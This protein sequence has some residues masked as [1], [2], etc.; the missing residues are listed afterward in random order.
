MKGEPFGEIEYKINRDPDHLSKLTDLF[1][2][3][4]CFYVLN[5]SE[6]IGSRDDNGFRK[7]VEIDESLFFKRK[8]NIGKLSN[9]QL[10]VGE[11]ERGSRKC[12]VVFVA[13][14]NAETMTRVITKN[15]PPGSNIITD[16]WRAHEK[17]WIDRKN[18]P[19]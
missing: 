5:N 4:I 19:Y 16:K 12:F 14:R 8:Y 15:V 11:I 2:E 6:R 3:A 9:E 13:N 1:H 18:F 10:Y 17:A 7:I